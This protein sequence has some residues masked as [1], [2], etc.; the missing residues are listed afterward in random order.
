MNGTPG[1]DP[2]EVLQAKEHRTNAPFTRS[3]A[4]EPALPGYLS[5]FVGLQ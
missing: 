2:E 4:G 5:R 3:A 1:L